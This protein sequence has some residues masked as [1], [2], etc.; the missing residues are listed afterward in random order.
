MTLERLVIFIV[1][2]V[3]L[4]VVLAALGIWEANALLLLVPL[5]II[6]YLRRG[7]GRRGA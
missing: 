6:V 7:A 5:A 4:V 1:V 3:V 2:L